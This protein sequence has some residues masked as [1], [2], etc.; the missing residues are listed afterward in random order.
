MKMTPRHSVETAESDEPIQVCFVC[1]Q[2]HTAMLPSGELSEC[3]KRLMR[4]WRALIMERQARIDGS[5]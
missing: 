4:S 1:G 5:K 2:D 3:D